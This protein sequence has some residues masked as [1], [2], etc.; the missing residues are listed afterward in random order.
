LA[1]VDRSQWREHRTHRPRRDGLRKEGTDP[2]PE[3]VGPVASEALPG[4]FT[5]EGVLVNVDEVPVTETIGVPGIDTT[6]REGAL[7]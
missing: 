2:D 5:C 4:E 3:V 6:R 7:T 1:A